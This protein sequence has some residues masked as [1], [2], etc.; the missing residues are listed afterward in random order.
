VYF[1]PERHGKNIEVLAK[2]ALE[3]L[4]SGANWRSMGDPFIQ[5][6]TYVTLPESEVNRLFGSEF[7]RALFT[8]KPGVWN[9]PI[10]SAFG[11]H[12]VKIEAIDAAAAANFE[13]IK[14]QVLDAWREQR[15]AQ[16]KQAEINKL[17]SKYKVI[18]EGTDD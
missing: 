6:R 7:A 11:L 10:G 5:K 13:P 12:L 16:A 4:R 8:L 2:A 18:V 14:A 17:V 15:A 3:K 9:N 1:S